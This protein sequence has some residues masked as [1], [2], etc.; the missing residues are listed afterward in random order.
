MERLLRVALARFSV[1]F[2]CNI[3]LNSYFLYTLYINP[4]FTLFGAAE[5][6][7][8][9]FAVWITPRVM[10]NIMQFP[11]DFI[12]LATVIPAAQAAYTKVRAQYSH[13]DRKISE[14]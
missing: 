2:I 11:I 3:C 8:N 13:G 4:D 6:A 7:R 9:A 14:R 12:L 1:I 10:K 5:D